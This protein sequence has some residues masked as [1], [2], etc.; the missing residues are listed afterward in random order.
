MR[1]E[2]TFILSRWKANIL[3][4][5]ERDLVKDTIWT[6]ICSAIGKGLGFLIPIFIAAWFGVTSETDAFFFAYGLIFF[7]SGVFA[8]VV[9]SVIVPFIAE[10]LTKGEDI[11]KFVGNILGVSCGF[12]LV[13][14][15]FFLL[16]IKP[17][18]SLATRFDPETV[19]LIFL[20]VVETAPL[21]IFL[22]WTSILAGALNAYKK[23]SFPA[24]SPGLRAL[25][26]IGIIMVFKD[27]YGVHA[28]VVGYVAGE[29][30]RLAS[31]LWAIR[32]HGIFTLRVSFRNS[33]KILAFLKTASYQTIG[34]AVIGINPIVDRAMA[35]WLGK[36]SVSVLHYADRLYMIPVTFVTTGLILTL[37]SHWS[38]RYYESGLETLKANVRKTMKIV[39]GLSL[40]ATLLLLML[41][42]PIVDIAFG[43]GVFDQARLAE[44][45]LVWVCFLLGFV[46]YVLTIVITRAQLVL[47]NTK[48]LMMCALYSLLLNGGSN[49]L[50]MSLY[51][52]KGIALA[53]I[54]VYVFALLYLGADFYRQSRVAQGV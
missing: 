16:L 26:C 41:H 12:L 30:L 11:G 10:A 4:L 17:V 19:Q 18:L 22:V 3:S 29:I 9:E 28:I 5:L 47:K 40:I 13:V 21:F 43:R 38:G 46:P 52:L 6:T 2:Q 54:F 31:L 42:R 27:T 35:S 44:V 32:W 14:L 37:L 1:V 45:D 15:G 50:L 51:G 25:V 20:L 48:V 34:M 24:I 53:K 8:P 39:G 23:F 36:G 33:P 7:L 49:Y